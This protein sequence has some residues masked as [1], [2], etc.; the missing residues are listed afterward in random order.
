MHVDT[1][2]LEHQVIPLEAA[3]ADQAHA[4]LFLDWCEGLAVDH[5]ANRA[6]LGERPARP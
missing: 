5:R 6:C 2:L 3:L 4:A 1:S